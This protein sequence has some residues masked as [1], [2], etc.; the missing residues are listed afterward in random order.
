MR[1][2]LRRPVRAS[3]DC[4]VAVLLGYCVVIIISG[5]IQVETESEIETEIEMLFSL[6]SGLPT[7]VP[8]YM[9]AIYSL[10]SY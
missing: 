5:V 3:K 7:D 8:H 6:R 1:W 10:R 4:L 2:I 9:Y